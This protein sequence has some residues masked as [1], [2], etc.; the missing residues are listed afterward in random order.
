M[1]L[2]QDT[3]IGFVSWEAAVETVE[4]GAE[5]GSVGSVRPGRGLLQCL[6]VL[7]GCHFPGSSVLAVF[8]TDF[9]NIVCVSTFLGL[10]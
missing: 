4:Y 8:S 5:E 3:V 7:L 6:P 1:D 10:C 9:T 2:P